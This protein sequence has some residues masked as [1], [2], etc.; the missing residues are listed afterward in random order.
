MATNEAK[1]LGSRVKLAGSVLALLL[2]VIF[3]IRNFDKVNVDF[4]FG[5]QNIQ[6]AFALIIAALLGFVVGFFAPG[7]R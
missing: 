2:L 1:D 4:V 5:S 6:L 7:R 3:I